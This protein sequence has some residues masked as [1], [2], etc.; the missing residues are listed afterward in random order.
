MDGEAA[1]DAALHAPAQDNRQS[2]LALDCLNFF[3]GDLQSG[4]GP[5]VASY[6]RAQQHWDVGRIGLVMSAQ[7]FAVLV[8][9]VP[10]GAL[11]DWLRAKRLLAASAALMLGVGCLAIAL[12]RDLLSVCAGETLIGIAMAVFGPV[13]AALT[14]GI[15]GSHAFARR[16][17]RN[18]G[19]NHAGTVIASLMA[20][21]VGHFL[22]FAD[23]FYLSSA[24]SLVVM[25][26]ALAIRENDIDHALAREAGRN[27]HDQLQIAKISALLKDRRILILVLSVVLFHLSNAAMLPLA[28]EMVSSREHSFAALFMALCILISQLTMAPIAVLAGRSADR[29]GRKP[30]FLIGFASLP[31]RALLF[32]L[33]HQPS[34]II[35]G[36]ILDGVGSGIFG[37]LLVIVAADLA[38]GTGRFNLL[39]ATLA[40]AIA[41]GATASNLLAGF[42]VQHEGF[43]IGFLSLG[44]VGVGAILTLATLMP[45]TA[46]SRTVDLA[47]P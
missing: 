47:Y 42:L 23:V 35:A 7:S 3:L 41:C 40:T 43:R 37:V 15:V 39:Q 12:A 14:L 26:S 45:E 4:V 20:G 11:V 2:L 9:Q 34:L 13:I 46:P 27:L 30:I 1:A 5:F 24:T 18:Q 19:F 36:E 6:L 17:G 31:L 16:T 22:G 38:R 8:V 44:V 29:I 32:A 10:A 28:G 21:L 33:V 25:A